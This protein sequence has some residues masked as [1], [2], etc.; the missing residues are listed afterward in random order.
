MP[1]PTPAGDFYYSLQSGGANLEGSVT[2]TNGGQSDTLDF[3]S[4]SPTPYVAAGSQEVY[5]SA[6]GFVKVTVRGNQ[7][8][9]Q[10]PPTGHA[11]VEDWNGEE[12]SDMDIPLGDISGSRPAPP[13]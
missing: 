10:N 12:W 6:R 9:E 1:E 5:T 4:M 11:D 3:D 13:G 2:W 8:S 7:A